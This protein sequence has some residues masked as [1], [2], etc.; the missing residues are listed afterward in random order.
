MHEIVA[1]N[2]G[3]SFWQPPPKSQGLFCERALGIVGL[4]FGIAA[5]IVAAVFRRQEKAQAVARRAM[6]EAQASAWMAMHEAQKR[7]ARLRE[8]EERLP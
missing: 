6:R 1:V 5:F 4:L 3:T 2:L 8:M 7:E